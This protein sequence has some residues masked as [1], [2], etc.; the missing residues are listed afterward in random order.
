M[1]HGAVEAGDAA[2]D[3]DV[4]SRRVLWLGSFPSM[5]S[6]VYLFFFS[7]LVRDMFG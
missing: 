4:V 7:F 3:G 5:A 1:V 2:G 6:G